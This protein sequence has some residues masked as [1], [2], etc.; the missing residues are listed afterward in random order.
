MSTIQLSGLQTGIDTQSMIEQLMQVNAR[1]LNLYDTKREALDT[2][3]KTY[4]E[5]KSKLQDY[6]SA[7]KK[8]SNQNKLK[9]FYVNSSDEDKITA[10]ASNSAYEG[11]NSIEVGQLATSDKRIHSGYAYTTDFV[12]EGKFI[13]SYDHEEVVIDTTDETTLEDLVGLINNN[14]ENP[15]ISASLLKYDDGSGNQWHLVLSG[16]DSGSD[17]SININ[18]STTNRLMADDSFTYSSNEAGLSAR[19]ASLDQF[20]GSVGESDTITISGTDSAGNAISR[21]VN[22]TS[23]TTL[24][25]L[26]NEINIAYDGQATAKLVNGKLYLVDDAS[27]TSLTTLELTYSGDGSLTLPTMNVSVAGGQYSDQMIAELDTANF[28]Q[29]QAAQD[30]KIKVNGYPPGEEEWITNS[31]NTIDNVIS[32]VTLYL[33]DVT[34]EGSAIELNLTRNTESL[35]TDIQSMVSAY[36]A[37][38]TFIAEKTNY[39]T[40]TR[41]AGELN[42]DYTTRT[43]KELLRS[44]LTT[45]ADGFVADYDAF[46]FPYEIGLEVD[47]DGLLEF[48]TNTFDEAIVKNYDGVLALLGAQKTGSSSEAAIKFYGA[49]RYTES[50]NYEVQTTVSGGEITSAQIRRQGE[51][52]WRDASFTAGSNVVTGDMTFDEQ[53]NAVYDENG[54]QF[55]VDLSTDA[56]YTSTIRVKFGVASELENLLDDILDTNDGRIKLS[57]E[58]IDNKIEN[59]DEIIETET[60]RLERERTRLTERFA[61]ME[62][63]MTMIQQQLQ[64][65]S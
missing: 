28:Q 43:I 61:R 54:L 10:S 19:I 16:K 40:Q 23:Q 51:T 26:V 22:L 55:T 38:S 1:R 11:S 35:K 32:G 24:E 21:V 13:L 9:S 45:V 46:R 44:P 39:N 53:G 49:S 60:K 14:P 27:G 17:Y 30:S 65:L 50:G 57:Q 62:K 47:K 8:L 18:T 34:D 31:G 63:Y 33:H 20:S 37:L 29:T 48:D 6:L 41:V 2:K 64:G 4:N 52:E 15:G 3:R 5:L 58:S 7:V 56:T 42:G 12:G 36:N 25:E 59:I